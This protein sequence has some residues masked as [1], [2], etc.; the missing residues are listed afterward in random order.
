MFGNLKETST[1]YTLFLCKRY[2]V[3]TQFGCKVYIS[4]LLVNIEAQC[5]IRYLYTMLLR[6][7]TKSVEQFASLD[8]AFLLLGLEPKDTNS[9]VVKALLNSST[10]L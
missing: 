4:F 1:L 9:L 3:D 8:F 7:E 2:I 5:R 6:L 10:S